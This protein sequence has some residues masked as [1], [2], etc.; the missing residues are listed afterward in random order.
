MNIDKFIENF[1]N[2]SEDT[3]L[4]L[5][6]KVVREKCTITNKESNLIEC[7]ETLTSFIK[8]ILKIYRSDFNSFEFLG[9]LADSFI[10]FQIVMR[11]TCTTGYAFNKAV[12]IKLEQLAEE[13]SLSRMEK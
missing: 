7:A 10:S 6:N 8:E 11:L 12:N 4:E 13:I 9:K 3:D 2:A 1:P 5:L